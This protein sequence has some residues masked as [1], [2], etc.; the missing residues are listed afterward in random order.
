MWQVTY[1]TCK[2]D[3]VKMRGYMDR[4]VTP[5][6]WGPPP[7][8]KQ[9]LRREVLEGQVFYSIF[10]QVFITR[11]PR[12]WQEKKKKNQWTLQPF[13]KHYVVSTLVSIVLFL[14]LHMLLTSHLNKWNTRLLAPKDWVQLK[15]FKITGYYY[16]MHHRDHVGWEFKH[17]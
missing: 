2:R 13:W 12:V 10:K 8:C 17:R 7:S 1:L 9:A 14:D 5:P 16:R 6:T 4:R 11:I 3:H 15:L